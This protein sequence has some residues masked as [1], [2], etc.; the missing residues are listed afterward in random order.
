M[1]FTTFVQDAILAVIIAI[2]GGFMLGVALVIGAFVAC[3]L[4]HYMKDEGLD[5]EN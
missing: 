2:V 4:R 3:R 5:G 1:V